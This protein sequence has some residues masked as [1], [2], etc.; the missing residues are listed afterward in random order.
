MNIKDVIRKQ[1]ENW[2][3]RMD[4]KWHSELDCEFCHHSRGHCPSCLVVRV[5]IPK[6][7]GDEEDAACHALPSWVKWIYTEDSR[8]RA[9]AARLVLQDINKIAKAYHVKQVPC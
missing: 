5:L 4:G 7:K 3:K 9:A 1:Q 6:W 8:R 2:T